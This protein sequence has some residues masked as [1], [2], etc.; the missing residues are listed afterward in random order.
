M[1]AIIAM[2]TTGF[3][4]WPAAHTTPHIA[5]QRLLGAELT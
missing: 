5:I 2:C 3:I 1:W 4:L